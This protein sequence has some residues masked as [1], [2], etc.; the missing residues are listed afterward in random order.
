M[1]EKKEEVVTFPANTGAG[2]GVV[3]HFT[4]LDAN[5]KADEIS[6]LDAP[7]PEIVVSENVMPQL[8]IPKGDD[9]P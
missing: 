2:K 7:C 3:T 6:S 4:I 1:S 8:E 5:P 9:V